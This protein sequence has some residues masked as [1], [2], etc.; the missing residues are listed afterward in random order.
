MS[1][2]IHAKYRDD[3]TASWFIHYDIK[4]QYSSFSSYDGILNIADVPAATLSIN[5]HRLIYFQSTANLINFRVGPMTSEW[6]IRIGTW[7]HVFFLSSS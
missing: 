1:A 6:I 5:A 3:Y 7:E 4:I 2:I